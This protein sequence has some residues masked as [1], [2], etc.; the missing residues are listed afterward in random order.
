MTADDARPALE[1][2]IPA[3]PLETEVRR[4]QRAHPRIKITWPHDGNDRWHVDFPSG[5]ASFSNAEVM[6]G[7][8]TVYT[9]AAPVMKRKLP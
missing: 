1:H 3:L 9:S 5:D 4:F 6:M 2:R 8:L 7:C